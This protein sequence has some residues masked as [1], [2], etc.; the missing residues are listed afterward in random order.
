M[1]QRDVVFSPEAEDDLIRLF[2]FV[3]SRSDL[4]TARN[5]MSRIEIFCMKLDL[6]SERGTLRN[7]V[8]KG[9][10]IVGFERRLTIAFTV[11]DERLTILKVFAAGQN[12]E[13]ADW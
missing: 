8:R 9:L 11:D 3:R 4:K 13:A 6:A 12:W 7:D 10:R 5:Y 1:K 2:D